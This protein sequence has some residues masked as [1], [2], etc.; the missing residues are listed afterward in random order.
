VPLPWRAV[1]DKDAQAVALLIGLPKREKSERRKWG[2]PFCGSSDALHAYPGEGAGFGCWAACGADQPR[3]CRGYSII[4]VA[5]QHWGTRPADTCRRLAAELGI[6]YD[7]ALPPGERPALVIP[8]ARPRLVLPSKQEANLAAVRQIPGARLPPVL[9]ADLVARLRLTFRGARY[10]TG[11]GLDAG[12]ARSYGFRSIDGSGEWTAVGR[13][14]LRTYSRQELAAAGFPLDGEPGEERV[15]LPFSGRLP[16]LVIPFFRRRKLIGIRFRNILPDNPQYKHNR[17]RNLVAAKPLWP[18]NA[19][20]LRALTVHITE[21]EIDGETLRQLGETAAGMYSAGVWLD[22][23]T[24]ELAGAAEIVDW[25]DCRDEKRAGDLGA[26]A[27]R[28]R[29]V[30]AFGDAWVAQ[31]WRR[32]ITDA[33]PNA[34]HQQGRLAPILRARPWRRA[35][36]ADVHVA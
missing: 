20:A 24:E 14:L 15:T 19:D 8:V 36:L 34:L 9:Y 26:E 29:L 1:N 25:H 11:R 30:A 18:F 35:E 28:T 2:C 32:M 33:D 5:A 7:D 6:P 13:Y 3:L 22:H 10:L 31:R 23:W 21:G 27:L 16:A 12:A 17:Y 4:D